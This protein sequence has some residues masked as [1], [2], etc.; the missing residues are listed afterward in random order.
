MPSM[1]GIHIFGGSTIAPVSS[2][3]TTRA[4]SAGRVATAA[5]AA[6]GGDNDDITTSGALAPPTRS[7][8][9]TLRAVVFTSVLF[10]RGAAGMTSCVDCAGTTVEGFALVVA[11]VVCGVLVLR[12]FASSLVDFLPPP[13]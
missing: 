12:L 9:S 3:R 2:G 1:T 13:N 6:G 4:P 7:V 8:T 11:T 5:A 10:T